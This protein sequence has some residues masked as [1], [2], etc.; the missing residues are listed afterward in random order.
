[1]IFS[2]LIFLYLFLP[3]CLLSYAAVRSVQSRN[4]VLI[5]FSLIFYAWG[6][7]KYVLLLMAM[8]WFDWFF[9][10][11]I[12]A[13][14]KAGKKGRIWLALACTVN[15]GMIVFFKY[16]GMICSIFAEP[17]PFISSI[18]LW[19]YRFILFSC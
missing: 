10:L 14:Q 17:G 2:S 8:A 9:A 18:A 19:V 3:L 4:I 11:R 15:L 5:I 7:P 12:Q 1:M 6:E 16:S 13:S